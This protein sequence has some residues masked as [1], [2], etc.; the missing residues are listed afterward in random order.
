MAFVAALMPKS[1]VCRR[2]G[3][4]GPAE[5]DLPGHGE[6]RRC[7]RICGFGLAEQDVDHGQ[8][9]HVHRPAAQESLRSFLDRLLDPRQGIGGVAGRVV[10][11]GQRQVPK[12]NPSSS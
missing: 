3:P 8:A 12:R 1:C 4:P 9:V 2:S 5:G 10:G 11:V 7:G 6:W